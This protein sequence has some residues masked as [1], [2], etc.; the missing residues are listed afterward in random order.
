MTPDESDGS[1]PNYAGWITPEEVAEK[2]G[3]SYLTALGWVT[4]GI[5]ID[6][7][8]VRL[9][10]V[11]LGGRWKVDPAAVGPFVQRM[12]AAALGEGPDLAPPP[13]S[14]TA[15]RRRVAASLARLRAQGIGGEP[16]PQPTRGRQPAAR[17]RKVG[18][19]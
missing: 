10:A 19:P 2:I 16:D 5:R 3:V 12:T 18:S 4:R 11:K 17:G 1:C 14:P 9:K 6:R 8:R 15:R 13:E 7:Q